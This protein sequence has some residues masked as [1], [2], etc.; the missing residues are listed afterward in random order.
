M[1]AAVGLLRAPPDRAGVLPIYF[2]G[3]FVALLAPTI[4]ILQIGR[5]L[6]GVGAAA[7]IS[8]SR[9]IVRDLFVGQTSARIMN[10]IGLLVGLVPP[11]RRRSA[12]CC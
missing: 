9:A 4:H 2:L 10:R 7:G 5:A 1:R 8:T 6:Q 11:F 3:S 12:A